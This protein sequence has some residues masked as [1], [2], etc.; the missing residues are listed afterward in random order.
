MK[1]EILSFNWKLFKSETVSSITAVTKAW[2]ITLLNNHSALITSLKPS[3]LKVIY[4]DSNNIN[5]VE[6]FAIWWGLLETSNNSTKI[7]ID[8]L[9]SSEDVNAD[10]ALKAQKEALELMEKYKDSKNKVD[11]EKFIQAED[12][13]LKSIAQLKLSDLK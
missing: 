5:Q 7:L 3:V 8:M 6:H 11:M 13:L 2:E 10:V 9:I 12:M 4:S 1:L